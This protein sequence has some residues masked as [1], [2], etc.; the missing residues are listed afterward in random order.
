MGLGDFP[1]LLLSMSPNCFDLLTPLC[2]HEASGCTVAGEGGLKGFMLVFK[3]FSL[4]ATKFN[5][6]CMALPNCTRGREALSSVCLGREGKPAILAA[7]S[8]DCHAICRLEGLHWGADPLGQTPMSQI[9]R[10]A[11]PTTS[12]YPGGHLRI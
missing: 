11:I 4:E 5:A 1:G 7:T 12:S 9:P 8:H 10:K 6:S 3:C 2:Q